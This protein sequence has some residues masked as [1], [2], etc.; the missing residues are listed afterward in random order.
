MD[1]AAMSMG[2]AQTQLNYNVGIAMT[3]KVMDT[4]E[5]MADGLLQMMDQQVVTP[6][7]NHT[8]DILA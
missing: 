6:P 7:S 8:L 3:K 5:V 2:Y 1:I 4:Q